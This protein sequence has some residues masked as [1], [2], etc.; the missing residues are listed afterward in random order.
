[1]RRS[2]GW[3]PCLRLLKLKLYFSFQKRYTVSNLALVG[4]N[5]QILYAAAGA[6]ESAHDARMLKNVGWDSIKSIMCYVSMQQA[7]V[8]G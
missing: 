5:K 1:M 7:E 2:L 4:Y 8:L 3:F 6:P